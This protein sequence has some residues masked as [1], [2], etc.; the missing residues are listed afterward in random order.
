MA[1]A[2]LSMRT[3]MGKLVVSG[4]SPSHHSFFY[5]FAKG[6]GAVVV[7]LKPLDKAIADSDHIYSVASPLFVLR[8]VY[9]HLSYLADSWE[10]DQL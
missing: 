8:H 4:Y 9:A 10:L 1:F 6:E 5:S 3:R 7:V 2:S